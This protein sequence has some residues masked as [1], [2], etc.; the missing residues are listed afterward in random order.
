LPE[1][2]ETWEKAASAAKQAGIRVVHPRIGI[3]LSS[4]GGAL[5]K[6]LPIFALGAGGM[7]GSGKQYM[8][9]IAID[10]LINAIY[11]LI[12]TESISGPVNMTSPRPVTNREFT[13]TLGKVLKRPTIIKRGQSYAKSPVKLGI[14]IQ[15]C[16]LKLS[17]YK[18]N[19]IV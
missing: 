13:E 8:S 9:W 10:D 18:N 16:R 3:V 4:K 2:C 7:L 12:I 6:L 19:R 15:I 1:V 5:A 11:H 14:S 17:T